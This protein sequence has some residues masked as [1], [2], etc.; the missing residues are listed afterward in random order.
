MKRNVKS[1]I[2]QK[3]I[4]H[5]NLIFTISKP[6][7]NLLRVNLPKACI[8][9]FTLLFLSMFLLIFIDKG[10]ERNRMIEILIKEKH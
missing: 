1:V 10:R 8:L 4:F 9:K 6:S 3:I 2:L 5:S 7:E